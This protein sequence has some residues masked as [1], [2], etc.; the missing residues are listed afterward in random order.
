MRSIALTSAAAV[1]ALVSMA[2]VVS[3]ATKDSSNQV[4]SG[5]HTVYGM[6][7]P[8]PSSAYPPG[9]LWPHCYGGSPKCTAAGY[10]NLHSQ[11]VI[12]GLPY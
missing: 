5:A 11:R 12:Q 4:Q 8:A 10:P 1:V 3:A 9:D 7:I 2:P 6:R